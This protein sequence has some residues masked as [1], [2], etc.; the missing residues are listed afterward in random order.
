MLD[1]QVEDLEEKTYT[2]LVQWDFSH[3]LMKIN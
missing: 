3:S 1:G 2:K